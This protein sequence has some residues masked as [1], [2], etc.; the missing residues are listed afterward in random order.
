MSNQKYSQKQPP[1]VLCKKRRSQKFH[2]VQRKTPVPKSL[3]L[4]ILLKHLFYRAPLDNCFCTVKEITFK[5]TLND[6]D[7]KYI[8]LLEI[9][10]KPYM[11]VKRFQ[12]LITETSKAPNKLNIV[13]MKDTLYY[14]QN[15]ATGNITFKYLQPQQVKIWK[16]QPS[17]S[18]Y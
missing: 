3:F 5:F 8:Q 9:C 2:K 15:K 11:E 18:R 14:R 17:R 12:I 16:Q 10:K 7:K 6:Y 13:F 1:E 4:G